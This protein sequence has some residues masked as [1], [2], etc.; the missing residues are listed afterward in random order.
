L[1]IFSISSRE[2]FQKF[3]DVLRLDPINYWEVWRKGGDG[4]KKKKK[5]SGK[6]DEAA[7]DHSEQSKKQPTLE[8]SRIEVVRLMTLVKEVESATDSDHVSFGV[9]QVRVQEAKRILCKHATEL[10]MA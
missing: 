7:E 10:A 1:F 6:D 4:K 2:K 5:K 9:F 3:T 8:E